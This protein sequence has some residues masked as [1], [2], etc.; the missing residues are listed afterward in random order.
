MGGGGC[1]RLFLGR[2]GPKGK[3]SLAVAPAIFAGWDPAAFLA[4]VTLPQLA[5][6]AAAAAPLALRAVLLVDR[7]P[8]R[9]LASGSPPP[10]LNHVRRCGT[11]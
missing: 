9:P 1:P 6:L 3:L 10:R 4:I 8:Q 2:A 7:I 5:R 11:F